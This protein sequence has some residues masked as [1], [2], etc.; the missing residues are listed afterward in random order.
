MTDLLSRQPVDTADGGAALRDWLADAR[1]AHPVRWDE[2]TGRCHVFGHEEAQQA[3]QDPQTF[4]SEFKG[5]VDE[6]IEDG[7]NF[8]DSHL[9]VTDPPRHGRLRR[10]I[11]QAFTPKSVRDLQPRI[12]EITGELLDRATADG[13]TE[14]DLVESLCKPLPALVVAELLG[15]PAEDRDRF[16][17]WADAMALANDGAATGDPSVMVLDEH[18]TDPVRQMQDYVLGH[19][20][21]RQANPGADL[22]SQLVAA[23]VDGQRLDDAELFQIPMV[24]LL[25]GHISTTM[26]LGNV[27]LVLD[28]H[29]AAR[30]AAL[31]DPELLAASIDEAMRLRPAVPSTFRIVKKPTTLG[32]V[33]VPA[34]AMAVIWMLS[35]NY[36]E[37]R[38]PEPATFNPGRGANPHLT[39]AHG[40]HFCLGAQLARLEISTALQILFERHPGLRLVP[41]TTFTTSPLVAGPTRLVAETG[42]GRG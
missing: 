8:M 34:G 2:T 15:V 41:P 35:A 30:A 6:P 37:R 21:D 27:L 24:L 9:G 3:L 18:M 25:A 32:S 42:A 16:S 19:V 12:A 20:R 13:G 39:F 7:P 40:P 26:Q 4:S 33:D 5:V 31:A 23:E 28:E 10:L 29:P 22:I 17:G 38:F 11:S 14:I 1:R 36:D